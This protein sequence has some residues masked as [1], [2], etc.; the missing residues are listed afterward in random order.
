MQ[1]ENTKTTTDGRTLAVG[2]IHGC[3]IAWQILQ[4]K[5]D[6]NPNDTIVI[7]GDVI[8]RGPG[9]KQVID[10]LLELQDL[11]QLIFI[12]GNHEEMLLDVLHNGSWKN[13]WP[14]YGGLE[15]LLSYGGRLEDIPES[16]LEFIKTGLDY[17]QTETDI[18]VHANLNP[19]ADLLRQKNQDLRWEKLK[20]NEKN[21]CSGKRVI[22]GHTPQSSGEPWVFEGWVDLDTNCCRG[23]W[24][25]CLDVGTNL[26]YQARQTGEF[27]GGIPLEIS[28]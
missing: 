20:G 21:H 12:L 2:D 15:T 17:W 28:S 23:G 24:L 8:D 6:F 11:C 18:F 4:N 25:T 5:L 19:A 14:G 22:C 1:E 13:A 3:H 16:H 26:I 10:N 7:L 27:R 9:S